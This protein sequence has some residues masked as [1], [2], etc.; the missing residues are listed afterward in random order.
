MAAP[1]TG[2]L[3]DLRSMLARALGLEHAGEPCANCRVIYPER[4]PTDC[5]NGV[6]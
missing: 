1:S 6:H 3:N 2:F 5:D 4:L